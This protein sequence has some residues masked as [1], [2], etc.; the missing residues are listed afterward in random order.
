MSVLGVRCD[1]GIFSVEDV[2][3]NRVKR[4]NLK[5]LQGFPRNR[6]ANGTVLTEIN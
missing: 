3:N 2:N 1:E 6:H 5:L 4:P